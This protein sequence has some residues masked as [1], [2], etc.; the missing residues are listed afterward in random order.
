MNL[1]TL[2]FGQAAFLI[3][4]Y[5][6]QFLEQDRAQMLAQ[7]GFADNLNLPIVETFD[8]IIGKL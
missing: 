5:A 3:N 6:D 7:P 4:F 1:A 8:F 2:I